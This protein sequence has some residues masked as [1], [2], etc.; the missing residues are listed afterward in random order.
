M[1]QSF[2]VA[3]TT[4]LP[5]TGPGHSALPV[6][7]IEDPADGSG[8]LC[9]DVVEW[10][11]QMSAGH[12][13]SVS[14]GKHVATV[15]KFINFY[16]LYSRDQELVSVHDQT[17]SIFAYLDF[18]ITGTRHL[19]IDHTLSPLRWEGCA[20]STVRAEFRHLSRYFSFLEKYAGN[21]A[22]ALNH[23]LFRLSSRDVKAL[24][25]Q[26]DRDF[27]QHLAA[28]RKFWADLRE[29]DPQLPRRFRPT[30][31]EVGFRPFPDEVEVQQIIQAERN[32]V[33]RA[34]WILLAYGASHRISEVLQ[35][36]QDDILPSYYNREFFG[37]P[38]DDMPLVLISH[39]T[40]STWLGSSNQKRQ[41]RQTYLLNEY[42]IQP[43]AMLSANDPLYAGFKTKRVY[44]LHKTAK[45]WWLNA[46][47]AAEFDGCVREIQA[48]HIRFR[49][50]RKHPYFFVN[51][52][53]SDGSRGEPIKMKRIESAWVAACK[54]VGVAPYK[55]GRNIHGLR[56]F[57]K[58]YAEQLGIPPS[59]IQIMRGDNSQ[60]S[61]DDYGQCALTVR[62]ALE[63]LHSDIQPRQQ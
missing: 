10:A 22:Q 35:I 32:P 37:S 57:T 63:T 54:R 13:G 51:M 48:F 17:V 6:I 4:S 16:H 60:A 24:R 9:L 53:A 38:P 44:G 56:H 20:K 36:W 28:H 34:I 31:R 55:R 11:S 39:P 46:D 19:S 61:Q 18:R 41:T 30:N 21:D 33:F 14:V 2:P 23:K 52:F 47:A 27:F 12:L 45:T 29:G 25:E 5:L 40:E 49:T 43:R 42:G 50:S 7:F 8:S 59:M 3:V 15:C 1:T 26:S 58:Y 62:Q